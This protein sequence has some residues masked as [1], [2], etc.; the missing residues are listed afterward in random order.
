MK[1]L[2]VYYSMYGHIYKMAEAAADGVTQVKGAE[3]KMYRVPETLPD[4]ALKKMGALDFQKRKLLMSMFALRMI[5]FLLMQLYLARQRVSAICV[6]RCGNFSIL[7]EEFG[8]K[9][10]L[11][12]KW[13]AYLPARRH[14]M[15]V[16]NQQSLASILHY[17]IKE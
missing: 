8:P 13:E 9:D 12:V 3:V 15:V 5:W 1:V 6:V 11:S 7:L 17:F 2:I 4:D 10:F 16:R 14:N